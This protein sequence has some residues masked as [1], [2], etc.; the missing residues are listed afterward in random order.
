MECSIY[1]SIMITH[2]NAPLFYGSAVQDI[3]HHSFMF[4]NVLLTNRQIVHIRSIKK[5]Y[6][7]MADLVRREFLIFLFN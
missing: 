7:G 5:A 3:F 1:I 4:S 2:D 6:L